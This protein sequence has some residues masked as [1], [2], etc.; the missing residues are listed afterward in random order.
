[1]PQ[2][3]MINSRE[4]QNFQTNRSTVITQTKRQTLQR[5]IQKHMKFRGTK[6]YTNQNQQ[7]RAE[8]IKIN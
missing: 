7:A 5:D 6:R 2:K 8:K 3:K 4:M 1:M